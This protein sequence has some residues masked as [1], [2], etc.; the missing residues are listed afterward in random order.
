MSDFASRLKAQIKS[1]GI[2]Q[3]ELA[4]RAGMSRQMLSKLVLGKSVPT[5]PTVQALAAGLGVDCTA[6][7]TQPRKTK[8]RKG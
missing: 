6:F 1:S 3:S 2:T 4:R 8:R 7:Q 5:W